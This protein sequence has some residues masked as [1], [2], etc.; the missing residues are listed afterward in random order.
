MIAPMRP[1]GTICTVLLI[2]LLAGCAQSPSRTLGPV[3]SVEPPLLP[4][5]AP[6]EAPVLRADHPQR[7]TVVPGDTLWDIARR[8]LQ[9]PWRWQEIWRRNPQIDNP[10]LIYPGDVIEVFYQAGQP[11]LQIADGAGG[12]PGVVKLSPRVR[13]EELVQAIPTL[14]RDRIE[15]FLSRSQV[16]VEP[17]WLTAPYIVAAADSRVLSGSGQRIYARGAN[18]DQPLYQ[19]FRPGEL[20]EDPITGEPLGYNTIYLGEARLLADGDPATLVLTDTRREVVAGDRL[21][22]VDPARELPFRFLPRPAPPDTQ[23]F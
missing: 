7:Y 2:L 22:P 8:F 20:Y 16:V 10:D 21:F 13:V 3:R 6:V 15:N 23:G 11:R 12:K 1:A 14:P 4:T 18:F 5:P 17:R 9:S 19:V